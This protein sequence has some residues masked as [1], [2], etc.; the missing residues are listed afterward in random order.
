MPE[1][2]LIKPAKHSLTRTD[3]QIAEQGTIQ[4]F[5][6]CYLR[7]VGNSEAIEI[8]ELSCSKLDVDLLEVFRREGARALIRISLKHQR[9]DL[10][11]GLRY[12]SLT[13][14]H[15]FCFPIYSQTLD[16]SKVELDY[17]TLVA[18][19]AKELALMNGSHEH[20]AEL[21]MR[22]IQSCSN[23]EQ[24]VQHRRSHVE[25]LYAFRSS[26]IDTE[27]ALIF[28]HHLHPTPKSRQGLSEEELFVYSPELQGRF[29]LHYFRVHRSIV[30]E[31]SGLPQTAT[32]LIKHEL[33]SDSSITDEFKTNY[34]NEDDYALLPVHPWQAI[35]LKQQSAVQQLLQ[36]GL[37][38]DLGLQGHAYQPTSSIRTVYHS[39]AA[40]MLKLSLSVRITNS[41]RT[42]LYKELERSVEVHQLLSGL[43]GEELRDRFSNFTIIRD[44]AYITL[45]IDDEP[46]DGFATIL[47]ENP[48]PA[49]S[50]A[51]ATC[52]IALC[53]DSI[54]GKGSRLSEIIQQL[55]Q[56]E[57]R[58]TDAVSLDWF[59]RYLKMSLEPILWLY[60]THGIAIEAHQQN[61]VL[62]L[63][64]GYPHH[65]FYRDNQGYYYR[66]SFHSHLNQVLPGISEKSQ[67]ICDDA[68]IDERLGY[69]LFINNLFGLINAF[70]VAGLI[71]ERSLLDELRNELIKQTAS[72]QGCSTLLQTLLGQKRLR[73]K[74]NLLT[75]FH[76]LDELV[77]PV[78][79]QSV[80]VEID[81]P[82]Y[83]DESYAI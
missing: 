30:Q 13:G 47:R 42:N 78:S 6:N 65:F 15:L 67:T 21:M 2:T 37:L 32:A 68:V 64:D 74:A 26:F 52:L 63:Q 61:S 4:S 29:P 24:F 48:F 54:S 44:P 18:L 69:Y 16:G 38:Q 23:I 76:N 14:R 80:Y 79:T 28:G 11:I 66:R 35:F 60:F 58:S 46:V 25:K 33:L 27:Q 72:A 31:G 77:G 49:S 36:T 17:V 73:C 56:R 9:V 83:S 22:V 43:V 75:R 45:K 41:V 8:I 57:G 39:E 50:E 51:D 3:K 12:W 53:Q 10:L 62:Q 59:R 5:L 7:E 20:Q 34:C 81:N 82:L 40:F 70:G 55:A 71:D 1:N 19:I